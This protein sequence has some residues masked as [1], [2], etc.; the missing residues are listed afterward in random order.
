MKF[1]QAWLNNEDH[2]LRE[3]SAEMISLV[4]NGDQCN[5][6]GEN[7]IFY[8]KDFQLFICSTECEKA[9]LDEFHHLNPRVVI[10]N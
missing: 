9:L 4:G 7:T 3:H 5:K 10:E 6:C 2:I 8:H 1:I